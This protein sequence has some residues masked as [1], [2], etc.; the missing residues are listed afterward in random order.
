MR[1]LTPEEKEWKKLLKKEEA[2]LKKRKEK[3]E[4]VISSFLE[5][6]IPQKLQE[7][8]D[9]AFAKA[10][11]LIFQKGSSVIEK[12]YQ[13][14][15][16]EKNYKI[17]EYAYQIRKNRK[18]L[19]AFSKK[20]EGTGR[21][22]LLLS[23]ASGIGMGIL[24]IGIPDIPIFTGMML[25]SIYEI[26]VSY[27]Y[28]YDTEEEQYFILLLIQGVVSYGEEAVRINEKI[29]A[30][31]SK[32]KLPAVYHISDTISKTAALLSG[33]LLYMKFLQGIPIAGAVGG[34]YDAVYMK[35]VTEYA[36][37]KYKRRFLQGKVIKTKN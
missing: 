34:I 16:F 24:G 27:G 29:N 30:L 3:K 32:E 14:D 20:A 28:K 37:L 13:K 26:A 9:A 15:E 12:T 5:E 18:S 17:Q 11:T 7:T 19:K 4:S 6:K 2:Y 8:L 1:W 22:N 33:E 31:I 10:F 21:K 35:H 25:R 23:G 36:N